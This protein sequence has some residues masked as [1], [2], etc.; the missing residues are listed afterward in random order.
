MQYK[1]AGESGNVAFVLFVEA[2]TKEEAKAKG[3]LEAKSHHGSS[4][5]VT[6]IEPYRGVFSNSYKTPFELSEEAKL[7]FGS[8]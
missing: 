8:K 2:S 3:L 1:V 5:Q 4:A 6:L 7:I